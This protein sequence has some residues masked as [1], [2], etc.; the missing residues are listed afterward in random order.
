MAVALAAVGCSHGVLGAGRMPAQ[1]LSRLTGAGGAAAWC[2]SS[3]MT[4]LSDGGWVG[5]VVP[6]RAFEMLPLNSAPDSPKNCVQRR[7]MCPGF[8]E[9]AVTAKNLYAI[10]VLE[11]LP[12]SEAGN[13]CLLIAMDPVTK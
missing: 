8:Q 3:V 1:A 7:K 2:A 12:V 11:L 4:L 10:D 5:P 6:P 13:Q 9:E